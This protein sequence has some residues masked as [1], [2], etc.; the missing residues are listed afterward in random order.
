[1]RITNKITILLA[2]VLTAN[3]L[4]GCSGGAP[5]ISVEFTS[6]VGSRGPELIAGTSS[7][8]TAEVG[9]ITYLFVADQYDG[10]S[11]FS[12]AADGSLENVA[13]VAYGSILGRSGASFVTTADVGGNTYLYA[14]GSFGKGFRAFRVAANGSLENVYN[15]DN[16]RG[17]EIFR[18]GRITT[19]EV[20]GSTYL[21]VA[22][23]VDDRLN[24][25]RVAADG[26]LKN[27]YHV[28]DN[29][30]L[31]LDG[32]SS[33]TTT[34]I[35]GITY[36]FVAGIVDNGVSV[37][38]VADDGSLTSALNINHGGALKLANA[39]S[40]T[41]TKVDGSTYLFIAAGDDGVSTFRVAV[42]L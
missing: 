12:M 20:G 18:V 33:M 25:F 24:V 26:S 37:F 30:V 9:G 41:T 3:I 2:S 35:G 34:E 21:F 22:A 7:V 23:Q 17:T 10:V 38:S 4:V 16:S 42:G 11:V 40:V 36:L 13:N 6:I 31:N 1:M 19:A 27:V 8:A 14:V 15:L 5:S 32:M 29:K 28:D 39:R